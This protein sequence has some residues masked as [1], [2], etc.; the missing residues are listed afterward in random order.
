[1]TP[2]FLHKETSIDQMAERGTVEEFLISLGRWFNSGALEVFWFFF[3]SA[4]TNNYVRIRI[5]IVQFDDYF[6]RDFFSP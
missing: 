5:V 1:M 3:T 4:H 2:F 6:L